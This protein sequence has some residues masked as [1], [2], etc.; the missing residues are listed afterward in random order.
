MMFKKKKKEKKKGEEKSKIFQLKNRIDMSISAWVNSFHIKEK[1]HCGNMKAAFSW[2][3]EKCV[4]CLVLNENE[5]E[6]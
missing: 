2:L 6:K 3:S 5:Q 4:L 1:K